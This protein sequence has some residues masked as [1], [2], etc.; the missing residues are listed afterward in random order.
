MQLS[1]TLETI[2]SFFTALRVERVAWQ[3]R[4]EIEYGSSSRP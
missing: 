1:I 3:A 4:F 2:S